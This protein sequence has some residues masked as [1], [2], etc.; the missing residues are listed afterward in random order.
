MS[1]T[2]VD[3]HVDLGACQRNIVEALELMAPLTNGKSTPPSSSIWFLTSLLL[4]MNH[5]LGLL[6]RNLPRCLMKPA[7]FLFLVVN[8]QFSLVVHRKRAD[9]FDLASGFRSYI[10]YFALRTSWW[11]GQ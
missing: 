5:E 8:S 1:S 9:V 3:L 4:N 2:M 11:P 7:L 10:A 6:P